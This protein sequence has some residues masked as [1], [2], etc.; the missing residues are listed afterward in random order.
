MSKAYKE[1]MS[2]DV[3]DLHNIRYL[4]VVYDNQRRKNNISLYF[5]ED[6]FND[7]EQTFKNIS[8]FGLYLFLKKM[9]FYYHLLRE[10]TSLSCNEIIYCNLNFVLYT[11]YSC[12]RKDL[13]FWFQIE[14]QLV[15]ELRIN[16]NNSR[17]SN[18][19]WSEGSFDIY[20]FFLDYNLS[21]HNFFKIQHK[22]SIIWVNK[23]KLLSYKE[24]TEQDNFFRFK[25]FYNEYHSVGRIFEGLN[26]H[27]AIKECESK[28][29]LLT[30]L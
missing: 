11:T 30:H 25:G 10:K 12:E 17:S 28:E 20:N 18:E 8:N 6:T 5:E 16:V 19:M 24:H 22:D 15:N 2:I 14:K 27:Q 29:Y 13:S 3:K 23:N 26:F 7:R 9:P 1:M 4:K 21:H